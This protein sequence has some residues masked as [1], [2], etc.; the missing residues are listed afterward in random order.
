[1]KIADISSSKES[2]RVS[3]NQI[4]AWGSGSVAD[5]IL[6]CTIF[7]IAT[8]I[9]QVA[10]GIDPV[11]TGWAISIPIFVNA[12]LAPFAGSWSDN[13]RTR[14]G[15][16]R[17]F[18][19]IAGILSTVF[20]VAAWCPPL[21]ATLTFQTYYIII[22]TLMYLSI[23][24]FFSVPYYAL[25]VELTTDYHERTRLQSWRFVFVAAIQLALPWF[26]KLSI[27][28]GKQLSPEVI[29]PELVGI[30]VVSLAAG[31]VSLA[32]ILFVFIF[33][34]ENAEVQA[35]PKIDFMKAF[36]ATFQ[37]SAFVILIIINFSIIFGFFLVNQV[38]AITGLYFVCG[39]DKDF[40][41]YMGGWSGMMVGVLNIIFSVGPMIFL[42][43]R[44]GKKAVLIGSQVVALIGFLSTW[45]FLTPVNPWLSLLP[46]VL[47]AP[48][49][50]A[51]WIIG[52]SIGADIIDVDELNTGLRREGMY[53]AVAMLVTKFAMG[54]SFLIGSFILKNF[55]GYVTG[56]APA[57]EVIYKLRLLYTL[58][59]AG[60]TVVALIFCFFLP[61][62][63]QRMKEVRRILDERHK[64]KEVLGQ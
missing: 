17:P 39:G 35:Q 7:Y 58:V 30:R 6:S 21:G 36:V 44:F 34:R 51:V 15:R 19:L 48:G 29:N 23:Y 54:S 3:W 13:A 4:L 46:W 9:Y 45:I 63:A 20:F 11:V 47:I 38:A 31:V 8:M 59:P 40:A 50:L 32:A 37:N 18:I 52:A 5:N 26:Y 62:S 57:P 2:A 14:W 64:Q 24:T 61:I 33:C 56:S 60:F 1:M 22:C 12:L 10:M 55:G 49:Q 41:S 16:R 27:F 25:G 42:S 43:K 28:I 53:G